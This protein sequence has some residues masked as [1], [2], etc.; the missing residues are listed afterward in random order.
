MRSRLPG[1]LRSSPCLLCTMIV[2]YRTRLAKRGLIK[3]G[4]AGQALSQAYQA[5]SQHEPKAYKQQCSDRDIHGIHQ[6]KLS[7]II[8]RELF[9]GL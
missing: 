8:K 2:K 4:F 1:K 5:P 3:C 6:K 7:A 9:L